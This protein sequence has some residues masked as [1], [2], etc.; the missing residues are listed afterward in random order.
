M[1]TLLL[2]I[3]IEKI[4]EERNTTLRV[5]H[6][7]NS[8][9]YIALHSIN[10]PHNITL[11][12]DRLSFRQLATHYRVAQTKSVDESKPNFPIRHKILDHKT[13][14]FGTQSHPHKKVG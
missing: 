4:V 11:N 7:A 1:I 2:R 3:T 9:P 14:L 8:P 12:P 13:M 5:V 6:F 10:S